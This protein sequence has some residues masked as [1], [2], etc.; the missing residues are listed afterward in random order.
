MSSALFFWLALAAY[1]F[2]SIAYISALAFS[3]ARSRR[4]GPLLALAG[5]A[6]H[7]VSLGLRWYAIGHGPYVSTYE[8]LSSNTWIAVTFFLLLQ[9]RIRM[10]AHLGA[11]VMPL[12]FVMLGF[13]LMGSTELQTLSPTLQSAWL[14]VHIVFAKLTVSGMLLAFALSIAQLL[15]ERWH[16]QDGFLTKLPAV[17]VLDDYAYRL[18]AFSFITLTIMIIT[19]SIWA[20]N[21]WGHYW[22]WDP[23]ETWSLVVWLVY[24]LYL[25][26]RI[27]FTW[28]KTLSS[29][30]IVL[31]F[32]FSIIAFFIIPYLVKSQHSQYM[33]G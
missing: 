31:S 20:N 12:A 21:S 30:Y 16:P 6:L 24:G 14:L 27:T 25:H 33:V 19:G 5:L 23:T 28:S 2:S 1:I 15:K 13:A 17:D 10:F 7:S 3:H 26:G 11:L 9:G 32:V 22:S 4:L 8:I 29:W 18:V